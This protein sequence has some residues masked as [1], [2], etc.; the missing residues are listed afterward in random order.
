M[1]SMRFR[2]V[3][4]D[5]H[6]SGLIPGVGSRFSREQF[7]A[8]LKLG[9]V[10]SITVFSK[11]H[12]GY[13]YHP[14]EVNEQHP[15]LDFDLLGEELAVCKELGVRAPVYISAGFDEKEAVR[16]DEWLLKWTPDY[17]SDFV[18]KAQY[19]LLCYNTPYMD[20]LIAQIEEVM[21]KYNPCGVFLDI[22]DV[23]TCYCQN[24]LA[25]MRR[26]GLD[27]KNP[28]DARKQGED[29]YAEYCR[30]VEK[31]VRK[32]SATATIF[33]NAGNVTRGRRDI[34]HYNTHLELESLPTGGWGYDH[35][36]MSAAYS[37][38]LGMDF[39]GMTGKFHTSWGEFGGFKHPN[40]L[41]YETALSLSQCARCSVGDQLHPTAEMNMATYSLIGKAYAEVEKKEPWC[42]GAKMVADV[43]VLSEEAF[44][45]QKFRNNPADVGACRLLLEGKHTFDLIDTQTAFD[46]YK[47]LILPD[48][49]RVDDALRA[50]L[51]AY[52]ASGGRILATGDSGLAADEDKFVLPFGVTDKG[53][54]E[55][56]PSY[57]VPQ[58]ETVNGTAACIMYTPVRA[59]EAA[60]DTEIAALRRDPYFNRTPEHF[61]SHR[62]APDQGGDAPGAVLCG[63][64]AYVSWKLFADYTEYG[65]LHMK[66][67]FNYLMDRLL[68]GDRS[69][70]TDL[71]DRGVA[72]LTYQPAEDRYVN[73]LL[74]A[75][76][77]LRG[78]GIETIQDV[79]P[80][81]NVHTSVRLPAKPVCATL[82]DAAGNESPLD[83]VWDGTRA[84][85]V[86]DK[87]EIHAMVV[88][89]MK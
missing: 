49:I 9:H 47:L 61:C 42:V 53:V 54:C 64:C 70:I 87:M 30:R 77:T 5:F 84:A 67:L 33:H 78:K 59:I 2:Q 57:C 89:H 22:S 58:Y 17:A 60:A 28:A 14:T 48:E 52:L 20:L 66:E 32:Y 39:L 7:A 62:H 86:V 38:T 21:Q 72:T 79:V 71:P 50:R 12:H 80:L 1:D 6:T 25:D 37:R 68:G 23:R 3:H 76:T 51:D 88:W 24:C 34:A 81:Y 63:N 65:E 31:A 16:H 83:F 4:L 10:D 55:Y 45:T 46:G 29:V 82:V 40:A 74:Y 75:H 85:A 56:C 41:R 27:P 15:G 35:F 8:A 44:C 18:N 36:P 19:H 69:V 73:H 43:A 11:C 26:K 13:S